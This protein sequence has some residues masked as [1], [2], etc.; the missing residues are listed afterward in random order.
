MSET[1][2]P[3]PELDAELAEAMGWKLL[4]IKQTK[5]KFCKSGSRFAWRDPE[6]REYCD[7]CDEYPKPYSTFPAAAISAAE[8]M[9]EKGRISFWSIERDDISAIAE[10]W[11]ATEH[12]CYAEIPAH[13]LTLAL[14]AALKEGK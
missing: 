3:G 7:R 1:K 9:R 12:K 6:G 14:L 8:E 13:A 5:I 4:P 11:G 2:Q 10:A